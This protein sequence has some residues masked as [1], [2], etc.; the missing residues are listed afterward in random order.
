MFTAI[1]ASLAGALV[2]AAVLTGGAILCG[3]AAT[4]DPNQDEQFLAKLAE[5]SIPAV[6][7]E[8]TLI[9]VAHRDCRELDSGM[10]F[11]DVV[12]EMMNKS[13]AA[14]PIERLLPRE[15]IV[16]T[17]VRFI[18]AAVDVYCPSNQGKLPQ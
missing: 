13:F 17:N 8:P 2:T 1:T 18:T 7:N 3:G 14:N 4:A 12:D 16:S 5:E 9:A 11:D 15:R 6:K 10:A